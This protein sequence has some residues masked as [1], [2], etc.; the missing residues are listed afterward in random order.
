MRPRLTAL[1]RGFRSRRPGAAEALQGAALAVRGRTALIAEVRAL[2]RRLH[3]VERDGELLAAHVA[4]LTARV[5]RVGDPASIG[6]RLAAARLGALASYEQR[7]DALEERVLGA[8]H[9]RPG[10]LS[11]TVPGT[12]AEAQ[13]NDR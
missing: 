8:R 5:E 12:S 11:A 4:A 6:D 10:L 2:Q 9:A 3:T 1:W 7:I 13:V